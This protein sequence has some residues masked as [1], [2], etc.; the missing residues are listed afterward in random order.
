MESVNL[1]FALPPNPSVTATTTLIEPAGPSV[2]LIVAP[3][4]LNALSDPPDAT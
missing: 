3:V 4:A 1:V 2:P